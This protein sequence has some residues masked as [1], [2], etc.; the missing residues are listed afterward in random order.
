[1]GFVLAMLLSW[2]AGTLLGATTGFL[3][4]T[5]VGLPYPVCFG[6]AMV[7]GL[8]CMGATLWLCRKTF[9]VSWDY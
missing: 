2:A 1:M 8:F 5:Q 3:L 7:V 9:P 4:E 6:L